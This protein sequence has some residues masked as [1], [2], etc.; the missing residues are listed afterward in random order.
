M[1]PKSIDVNW[2]DVCIGCGEKRIEMK[3]AGFKW[4]STEPVG[5]VEVPFGTYITFK[6]Q[7]HLC[8]DCVEESKLLRIANT[9]ADWKIWW[10]KLIFFFF[11]P[12]ALILVSISLIPAVPGDE[13]TYIPRILA[14]IYPF[15][16]V[17][18]TFHDARMVYLSYSRSAST[19]ITIE[20]PG[21]GNDSVSFLLRNEN[22]ARL[23][24]KQNPTLTSSHS[25]S[26]GGDTANPKEF[27][28]KKAIAV[29]SPTIIAIVLLLPLLLI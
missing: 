26:V 18:V 23:F 24:Q 2:P 22:Y 6:V 20:P 7:A 5:S 29:I 16:G 28:N 27:P 17:T 21:R 15:I 13:Y 1:S 12:T 19:F 14:M 25:S 11:I 10:M 9:S 4:R 3:D 8:E